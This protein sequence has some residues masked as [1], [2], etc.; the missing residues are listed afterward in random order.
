MH[1]LVTGASSGIGEA[2]ACLYGARGHTITLVARRGELLEKLA[3]EIGNSAKLFVADLSKPGQVEG[4]FRE[5][6]HLQGPVD[7][8]VNNAG[9][10]I[11]GPAVKQSP[12]TG[13]KLLR[14][15]VHTPMRLIH[16]VLPGMLER[17]AGAIVNISSMAALVPT[18]GMFYYNASKAALAAASEALRGELRGTGVHVLTVYPGPVKTAMADASIEKYGPDSLAVKLLPMGTTE[19]LAKKIE[20]AVRRR[21]ARVVYPASYNA[22]RWLSGPIRWA[23]NRLTPVPEK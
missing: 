19:E 5:A 10:Q 23:T 7:I 13:E 21:K 3:K 12:E 4:W 6:E 1:V 17:R 18:P 22:S 11:V 14:L 20:A 16:L 2:I 15:N 8:L 9:M